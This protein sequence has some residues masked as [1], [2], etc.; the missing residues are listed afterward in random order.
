M[1]VY[2][3][4]LHGRV[5]T[6]LNANQQSNDNNKAVNKLLHMWHY[7]GRGLC[8]NLTNHSR[9]CIIAQPFNEDTSTYVAVKCADEVIQ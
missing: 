8:H 2:W 1:V 7:C 6:L 5:V 3:A 9:A 4:S